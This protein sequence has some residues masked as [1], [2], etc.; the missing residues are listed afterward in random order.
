[1]YNVEDAFS[2]LK[3]YKITTHMESVRRWLREGTIKGIP[4]K[5]RKE[6][7]LI[8]ED[9]LYAF[10]RS[11]LPDDVIQAPSHTTNDAKETDREAIRAEMWWELVGKNIFEDILYVKKAHVRDAV[12]HMGLSKAFETYAWES[13]REHKRGYATP[14]IPYLLDA[15]LFDGRRILL[16]TTYESKNEQ[17]MF[18][19]LEYLRQKK[20]KSV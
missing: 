2:L 12:A 10:I 1:M 20:I 17:I 19:V 11:R 18:A 5:S 14:R 8:R 3:T 16:D 9:D 6:G 7:W 4:P 15:A 13:I